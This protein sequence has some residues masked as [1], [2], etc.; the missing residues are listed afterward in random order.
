MNKERGKLSSISLFVF[1]GKSDFL[2]IGIGFL[3]LAFFLFG[4]FFIR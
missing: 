3:L 4:G 1:E 2:F